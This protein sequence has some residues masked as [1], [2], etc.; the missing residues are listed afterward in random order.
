[1]DHSIKEIGNKINSTEKEKKFKK[2]EKLFM[3]AIS[4]KVKNKEKEN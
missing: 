3:K 1:M 4:L 2:E